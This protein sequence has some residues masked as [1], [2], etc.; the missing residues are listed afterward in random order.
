[1]GISHWLSLSRWRRIWDATYGPNSPDRIQ[2]EYTKPQALDFIREH[3]PEIR[4]YEGWDRD[5]Q[6]WSK[7]GSGCLVAWVNECPI[8]VWR[9]TNE[10]MP[11]PEKDDVSV[12]AY[13]YMVGDQHDVAPSISAALEAAIMQALSFENRGLAGYLIIDEDADD[14]DTFFSDYGVDLA[15]DDGELAVDLIKNEWNQVISTHDEE[16]Q[17]RA[18][19][20]LRR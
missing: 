10:L 16:W 7:S 17:K 12:R 19:A 18:V 20:N 8:V 14:R 4:C 9:H 2:W 11:H 15:S 6:T 13:Q 1:M 5:D 3:G